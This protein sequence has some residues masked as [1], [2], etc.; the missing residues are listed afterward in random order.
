[1]PY[2]ETIIIEIVYTKIIVYTERERDLS[3][4]LQMAVWEAIQMNVKLTCEVVL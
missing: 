4:I 1:M 2:Y 3:Q